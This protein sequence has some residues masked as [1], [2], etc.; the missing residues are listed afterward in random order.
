M[1]LLSPVTNTSEFRA[2]RFVP[3][4]GCMVSRTR[5]YRGLGCREAGCAP[6]VHAA[7]QPS[8]KDQGLK[9]TVPSSRDWR[10][11]TLWSLDVQLGA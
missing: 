4:R 11:R 3:S 5:G 10:H 8:G 2:I 9:E 1:S 7:G 6:T